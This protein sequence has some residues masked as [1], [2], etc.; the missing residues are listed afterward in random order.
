MGKNIK[1]YSDN[2]RK[3]IIE[4]REVKMKFKDNAKHAHVSVGYDLNF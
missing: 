3:L 1:K 2:Q 4:L